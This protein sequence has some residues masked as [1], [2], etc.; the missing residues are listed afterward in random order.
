M[1]YRRTMSTGGG[2]KQKRYNEKEI[3]IAVFLSLSG[4]AE[5]VRVLLTEGK[6]ID[7]NATEKDGTTAAYVA[8]QEVDE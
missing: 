1:E 6:G 3:L 5:V 4:H 7:P 2:K 8:A